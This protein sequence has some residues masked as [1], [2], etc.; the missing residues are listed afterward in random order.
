MYSTAIGWHWQICKVNGTSIAFA[1]V[2]PAKGK[3]EGGAWDDYD[4]CMDNALMYV[5]TNWI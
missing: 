3:N 2:L 4:G 5:L 1:D